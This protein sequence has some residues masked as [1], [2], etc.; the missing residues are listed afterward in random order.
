MVVHWPVGDCAANAV[1]RK[2]H[3]DL[4]SLGERCAPNTVAKLMRGEGL[5]AQVGYKRHPG[6]YGTKP[7]VVAANQLQQDFNVSAP[8][9]VW[10]EP[11][12]HRFEGGERYHLHPNTRRLVVSGH[13]HR[14]VLT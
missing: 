14:P 6:K 8:D 3:H 2:I 9:T 5:R 4:L 11:A 13:R 7:A 12:R 1:R 10:G